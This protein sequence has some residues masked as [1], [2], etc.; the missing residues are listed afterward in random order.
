MPGA[1]RGA[2]VGLKVL[3]TLRNRESYSKLLGTVHH[4]RLAA[5][6]P[7]PVGC[8]ACSPDR[9]MCDKEPEDRVLKDSWPGMQ[10]KELALACTPPEHTRE[11]PPK[12]GCLSDGLGCRPLDLSTN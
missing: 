2:L 3:V 12:A 5:A 9:R 7:R 6:G 11:V 10:T 4:G 1:S 8:Y